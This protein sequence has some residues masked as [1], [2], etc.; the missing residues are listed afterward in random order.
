MPLT[1]KKIFH[2]NILFEEISPLRKQ[3]FNE[4]ISIDKVEVKGIHRLLCISLFFIQLKSILE[5]KWK[6]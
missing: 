5:Q 2:T 1:V 4:A 6:T 3:V